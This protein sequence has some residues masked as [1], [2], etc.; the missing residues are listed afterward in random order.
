[1][2]L[3]SKRQKD[4]S[5]ANK[6]HKLEQC[7][8]CLHETVGNVPVLLNPSNIYYTSEWAFNKFSCALTKYTKILSESPPMVVGTLNQSENSPLSYKQ[9]ICNYLVSTSDELDQLIIK[10]HCQD[11][12]QILHE[13]LNPDTDNHKL[14]KTLTSMIMNEIFSYL[15]ENAVY[16][17]AFSLGYVN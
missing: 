2:W 16:R 7:A 1:M 15:F 13:Y 10:Q 6:G 17:D 3:L 12:A 4:K 11:F 8:L 9:D 5:P 14:N